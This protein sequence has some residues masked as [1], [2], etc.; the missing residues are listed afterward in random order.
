LR[1][2]AQRKAGK[3][4]SR[5]KRAKERSFIWGNRKNLEGS[6]SGVAGLFRILRQKK[7][8]TVRKLTFTSLP[9]CN[10]EWNNLWLWP[11]KNEQ[12]DYWYKI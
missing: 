7:L 8:W 12:S 10:R 4:K 6:P 11:H 9:V 3:V 2:Q 5:E 1:T